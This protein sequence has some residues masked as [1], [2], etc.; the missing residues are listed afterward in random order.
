M[1]MYGISYVGVYPVTHVHLGTVHV[2]LVVYCNLINL[3]NK[4]TCMFIQ[5]GKQSQYKWCNRVCYSWS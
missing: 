1:Y 5:I 4:A 3:I 2:W